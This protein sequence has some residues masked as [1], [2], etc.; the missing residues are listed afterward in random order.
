MVLHESSLKNARW[1][2]AKANNPV[3]RKFAVWR[4]QYDESENEIVASMRGVTST[5][6]SW[7]EENET[8]HV[9]RMMRDIDP[10]F[11]MEGFGR[12]LREYI[13]PE[14]VDAYLSADR[15]A[16]RAWCSEATYNVL[17]ATLEVYLKQ[18]LIS[19]SKVLDIRNVDISSG[20]VLENE[21]PVLVV[22][23][24]TQEVLL[25]RN[26][27]TGEVA[28]GAEDKVEQC[29]YAAVFTRVPEDLGNELT[30]GWK[31]VEMARRSGKAYL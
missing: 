22:Q 23:F 3:L 26:A 5:I 29:I 20:K 19:S 30:A 15:D 11:T 7:F 10:T 28:V 21:Q 12:E 6:G 9:T 24:V 8:A 25:F 4:Q 13:V 14:I 18:G 17:W 16:L 1:E 31:V 27:K 2:E